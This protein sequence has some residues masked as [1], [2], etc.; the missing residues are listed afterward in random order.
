MA[1]MVGMCRTWN[2]FGEAVPVV[3]RK[4]YQTAW[5]KSLSYLNGMQT[6]HTNRVRFIARKHQVVKRASI[7]D[8]RVS[9]F[10]G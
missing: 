8:A 4:A 7:K 1:E 5:T 3:A 6:S 9:G 10:Y 2:R